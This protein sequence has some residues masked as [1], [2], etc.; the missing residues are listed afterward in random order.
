MT[1]GVTAVT[2]ARGNSY[3]SLFLCIPL[4]P[5]LLLVAALSDTGAGWMP[6]GGLL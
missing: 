5:V 4:W 1:G 3:S 2:C 6:I